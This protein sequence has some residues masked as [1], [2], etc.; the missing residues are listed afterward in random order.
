MAPRNWKR[1]LT[2]IYNDNYKYGNSLYSG[3]IDDIEK[4]YQNSVSRTSFRSD[5]GDAN[6]TT[7]ASSNI[8]SAGSA[9]G[10]VHGSESTLRPT[11]GESTPMPTLSPLQTVLESDL[12]FDFQRRP[13]SMLA[14]I[15]KFRSPLQVPSSFSDDE[16]FGRLGEDAF[17]IRRKNKLSERE[18]RSLASSV[19][20][21][22]PPAPLP[23]QTASSTG[24]TADYYYDKCRDL[25]HELDG[26]YLRVSD[27]ETRAKNDSNALRH[28]VQT[29]IAEL[30]FSLED[31]TAQNNE[32]QKIL[33]KQAKQLLDLQ[34]YCNELQRHL[35]EATDDL[36]AA[37]KRC[38]D[39]Q[40]ELDNL[41]S[42]ME[43]ALRHA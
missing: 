8:G 41:K 37:N 42:S 33:K 13:R 10:S 26:L 30:S 32:M 14:D 27:A 21:A 36:S 35:Q 43:S 19:R 28:K 23:S 24:V 34:G 18:N 31:T 12:D 6:L 25:K 1:P 11:G 16:D 5:R 3:A 15:S 4:R 39:L 29:E 7:F 17:G 38:G 20:A 22:A 2:T 40:R 9:L